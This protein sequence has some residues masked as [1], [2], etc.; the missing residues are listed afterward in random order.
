M[1]EA[2]SAPQEPLPKALHAAIRRIVRDADKSTMTVKQVRSELEAAQGM[3]KGG[4]ARYKKALKAFV[5]E[6]LAEESDAAADDS[7]K[8][9]RARPAR[10]RPAAEED[11]EDPRIAALKSLARAVKFGPTLFKGLKD[12]ADDDARRGAGVRSWSSPGRRRAQGRG[13]DGALRGA[14]IH[15]RG[16]GADGS[17]DPERAGPEGARGGP[18]GHRRVP[19]HQR[20]RP[21]FFF[22]LL[23]PRPVDAGKR[24]RRAAA[25]PAPPRRD[26]SDSEAE[27]E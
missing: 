9:K 22:L 8:K 21:A 25:T 11:A 18:R 14:R 13:D 2:P 19:D 1:S 16:R 7:P 5:A 12:L 15:L 23:S 26:D 3:E 17:G 24:S 10:A 20:C 6:M 4:C 27:F